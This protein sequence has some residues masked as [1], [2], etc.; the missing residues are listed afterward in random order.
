MDKLIDECLK[1]LDKCVQEVRS[2]C[3][4]PAKDDPEFQGVLAKADAY[5]NAKRTADTLLR[6][7]A[8]T[9]QDAASV[10]NASEAFC[11]AY[12]AFLRRHPDA[13]NPQIRRAVGA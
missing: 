13:I 7:N 5:H 12:A 11:K 6:L 9:D 10:K 3:A 1:R 4:S 8:L 2:A